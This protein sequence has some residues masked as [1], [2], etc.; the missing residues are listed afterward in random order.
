[1]D[2]TG[3]SIIYPFLK[4]KQN[5]EI[6]ESFWR[7]DTAKF[8]VPK[9]LEYIKFLADKN[10]ISYKSLSREVMSKLLEFPINISSPISAV[11]NSAPPSPKRSVSDSQ[12]SPR[13]NVDGISLGPKINFRRKIT[14]D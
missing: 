4:Y 14:F 10:S 11:S 8:C 9:V 13:M 1:M 12:V 5:C 6:V 7:L 2:S 3:E